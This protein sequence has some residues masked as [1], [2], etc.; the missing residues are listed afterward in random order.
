MRLF[1]VLLS[2]GIVAVAFGVARAAVAASPYDGS[3]QGT[4][5]YTANV[6]DSGTVSGSAPISFNVVGAAVSGSFGPVPQYGTISFSGSVSSTG[7]ASASAAFSCVLSIEFSASGSVSGSISGCTDQGGTAS[8]TF[9]ATRT[10]APPPPATTTSPVTTPA[11]SP[12]P[13]TETTRV[14]KSGQA[15]VEHPDGSTEPLGT[16]VNLHPG[17]TVKTGAN[18]HVELL[19]ANGA[20]IHLSPNSDFEII[21]LNEKAVTYGE[22][23][24]KVLY[25]LKC[26]ILDCRVLT[27]NAV[28]AVRGTSFSIETRA[29]WTRLRVTRHTVDFSNPKAPGKHVPV[30]AGFE[31]V[32]VGSKPPTAPKRF[33]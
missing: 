33:K 32:V 23:L 29:G 24:G 15:S 25:D 20:V 16:K 10:S 26:A 5:S 17:D 6:P 13:G 11:P 7:S 9:T 4:L 14:I 1:Q 12:S 19:L 30:K 21:T 31:S 2:V 18:G 28:V 8:G 3:Y 22:K 27:T